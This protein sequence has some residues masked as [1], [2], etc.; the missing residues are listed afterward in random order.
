M[1]DDQAIHLIGLLLTL[2]GIGVV[3]WANIKRDGFKVTSGLLTCFFG[4]I[5]ADYLWPAVGVLVFT[6]ARYFYLKN[7]DR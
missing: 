6:L 2:C 7:P 1:P 3:I 5:I 4:L